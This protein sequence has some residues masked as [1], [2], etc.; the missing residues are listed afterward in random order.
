MLPESFA[1]GV[2]HAIYGTLIQ[3]LLAAVIAVPIGIAAAVYLV[4]YGRGRLAK[5]TSF[6]ERPSFTDA[7][8]YNRRLGVSVALLD[9]K[10]D[11]YSLTAGVFSQ[12]IN[13]TSFA[14]TG[15]DA[16]VRGTFSP[17]IGIARIGQSAW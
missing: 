4:E 14:R 6:M 16:G 9:T 10:T 13:N 2:Y 1:G 8:N 5:T 3:A 12:E 17:R 15:W 11:R 7:F